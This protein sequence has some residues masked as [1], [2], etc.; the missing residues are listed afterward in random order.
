ME[1]AGRQYTRLANPAARAA[2]L[3]ADG[4]IVGWFQGGSEYGP[5]SLGYRSILADCRKPEI[6][7][8]LNERVKHR[9]PFAH[10]RRRFWWSASPSISICTSPA[11]SCCGWS[12]YFPIGEPSS[13]PSPT[14]TERL[15][16]R[17]SAQRA[18]LSSIN[19]SP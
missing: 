9:E 15:A 10:T 12:M 19:S 7:D 18:I 11:R 8:H 4:Q 3:I 5:R 16:Y 13:P 2:A 1:T 17:P 6:K 14:W